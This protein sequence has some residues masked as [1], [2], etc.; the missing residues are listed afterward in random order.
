MRR[1]TSGRGLIADLYAGAVSGSVWE[2]DK[3]A[4][5][6]Q[7]AALK[8]ELPAFMSATVTEPDGKLFAS[9]TVPGV[10]GK[11]FAAEAE[12]HNDGDLI[13]RIRIELSDAIV[14]ADRWR[15]SSA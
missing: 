8:T 11:P 13:G 3:D 12:I 15:I 1:S 9:V 4:T 7:L 6:A 10:T 2:F 5:T 14:Q